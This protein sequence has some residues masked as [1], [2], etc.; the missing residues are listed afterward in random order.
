MKTQFQ[1]SLHLQL[2]ISPHKSMNTYNKDTQQQE[3]IKTHKYIYIQRDTQPQMHFSTK[4]SI[5]IQTHRLSQ[6]T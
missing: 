1:N 2:N 3:L 6:N 4:L 5:V